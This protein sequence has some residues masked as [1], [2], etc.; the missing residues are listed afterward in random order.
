MKRTARRNF[1]HSANALPFGQR[2]TRH[3][4]GGKVSGKNLLAP[5]SAPKVG[6]GSIFEALEPRQMLSTSYLSGSTLTVV[7]D[8]GTSNDLTVAYSSDKK[9]V[10]VGANGASQSYDAGAVKGLAITGGN[11]ADRIVVAKDLDRDATI[12]GG[13]G[14]DLIYG[15]AGNDRIEGGSGAD[16]L[17]GGLGSDTLVGGEGDDYL[18]GQGD[19]DSLYGGNGFDRASSGY[20]RSY[21]LEQAFDGLPT[22]APGTKPGSGGN[23]S[24]PVQLNG[25]VLTLNGADGRNNAISVTYANGKGYSGTVNDTSKTFASGVNGVSITGGNGNDAITVSQNVPIPATIHGGAG[26]DVIEG[27]GGADQIYG[28]AGNDVLFGGGGEDSINGGSGN[29]SLDGGPGADQLYGGG[30]S[31]KAKSGYWRDGSIDSGWA[32]YTGGTTTTPP[33]VDPP[34]VNPPPVNPPPVNPPPVN[35]PP[36]NPPPV[37]P[38]ATDPTSPVPSDNSGKSPNARID[39][40]DTNIVAGD[41]VFV[42]GLNSTLNAGSPITARY[43][44]DFGDSGSKYNALVGFNAAHA[45]DKPGTY[46]V[47]LRVFNENRKSD[48]VT[49]T[50]KVAADNRRVIYVSNSGSDSNAGTW[51]KPI[52]SFDKASSMV[53]GQSNVEVLFRAGE[54][55]DVRSSMII[56]G[57]DT[58]IGSYGSGSK[59]VLKWYGNGDRNTIIR[60]NPSSSNLTVQGLTFDSE[61]T[62]TNGEPKGLPFGVKLDGKDAVI[63][64]NTFLNVNY[65]IQGS[66]APQGVLVQGNDAPSM[67]GIRGYFAWVDGSDWTF[68][69]NT[70][71]NVT[72]EHTVRISGGQRVNFHDND[73]TNADRRNIDRYDTAKGVITVQMGSYAYLSDNRINGPLPIGP[74][75]EADGLTTKGSRWRYAVVE[76]NVITQQTVEV[77]HGAEHVM[78]RNNVIKVNNDQAIEVDGYNSQYGRGVVDLSILNN[79]AINTSTIGRFAWFSGVADGVDME[80]NLYIA[81][82]LTI[83]AYHSAGVFINTGDLSGFT[84]I[85]HNVWPNPRILDYANG[86]IN[87]VGG[88]GTGPDVGFLSPAEWNALRAVKDDSFANTKVD[89][90]FKPANGEIAAAGGAVVPGV[91]TDINGAF[92]DPSKPWSVGAVQA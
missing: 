8:S 16:S 54:T 30:G 7:G 62:S 50:V 46:T 37:K 70:V 56:S 87:W 2:K 22:D 40:S 21:D 10:V 67:T 92:R 25:G 84:K 14:N 19:S 17:A 63:R 66:G 29:D 43:E 4:S 79:T 82:N 60:S 13:D 23:S 5:A 42:Q 88:A 48:T 91:F 32:G 47:T 18:D 69:G 39:A 12:Y 75:G 81:P 58:L 41:A 6:S 24:N 73:L 31:D 9:S 51:D 52:K 53:A 27:G 44:W 38:P 35:P 78:I 28:D 45:Y 72:R 59:P 15:G 68:L 64:D 34:P 57:R 90:N 61:Y 36:V 71:V 77:A 76:D 65:A 49:T 26:N 74:L 83:G 33:P 55:F 11:E 3:A 20:W 1:S 80:N 85:D 86:G 89:S